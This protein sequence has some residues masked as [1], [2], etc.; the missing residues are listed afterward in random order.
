MYSEVQI[1]QGLFCDAATNTGIG[2]AH[3]PSYLSLVTYSI[4]ITTGGNV[5]LFEQ[6]PISAFPN[7]F[8]TEFQLTAATLT[9]LQFYIQ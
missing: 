8:E 9:V 6:Q 5:M 3:K 2:N 1:Q 4:L 7:L